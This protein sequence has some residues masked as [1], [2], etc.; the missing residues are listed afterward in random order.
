MAPECLEKLVAALEA[1]PECDLAHCKLRLVDEIGRHYDDPWS[2]ERLFTLSSGRLVDIP[3]VRMAPFDGLLH[4][5]GATVYISI[6]QLLIRRNLFD[7][8]GLFES[9]W[10]SIG[11]FNWDMRAGLVAN[12]VHVPDTWGGWRIHGGQATARVDYY[13]IEHERRIQEMIDCAIGTMKSLV[14]Q[15]T[16]ER[17]QSKWSTS[18]LRLRHFLN[19]VRDR[20]DSKV[21]RRLFILREL[22]RGEFAASSHICARATKRP[23]WPETVKNWML[24]IGIKTALVPL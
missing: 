13:S 17:L 22:L 20:R 10:G 18:A 5:S 16:F 6:T 24:Q 3:H 7:K 23:I 2:R 1:C 21:A 15:A 9:R 11:D 14:G 8:I 4:L 19:G 12:T